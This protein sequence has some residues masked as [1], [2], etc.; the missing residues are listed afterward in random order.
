MRETSEHTI[1]VVV[2]GTPPARERWTVRR[3]AFVILGLSA[4]F[5]L[6]LTI[7]IFA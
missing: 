5:W 1:D 2:V 3:C 4:L 6:T 7:F